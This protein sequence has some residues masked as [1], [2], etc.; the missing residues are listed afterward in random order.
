MNGPIVANNLHHGQQPYHVSYTSYHSNYE[1][2]QHLESRVLAW[3]CLGTPS[4][5]GIGLNIN[6]T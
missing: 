6:T 1:F 2:N 3:E 5:A 4:A